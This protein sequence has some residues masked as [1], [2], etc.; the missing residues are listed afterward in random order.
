MTEVE[1][2]LGTVK[3]RRR[4]QGAPRYRGAQDEGM[5]CCL[6]HG[7]LGLAGGAEGR[8]CE[9][10]GGSEGEEVARGGPFC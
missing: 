8:S 3:G 2:G 10:R 9:R 6:G 1:L 7:W 4:R 5:R